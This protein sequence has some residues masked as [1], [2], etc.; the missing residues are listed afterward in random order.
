[1]MIAAWIHQAAYSQANYTISGKVLRKDNRPLSGAYVK[2]K[3]T[4]T[5]A[6]TDTAG[7]FTLSVSTEIASL[8]VS[9]TGYITRNLTVDVSRLTELLIYLEQEQNQLDE[10]TISTGYQQIPKERATGSFVQIDRDLLNRRVSTDFLSRLENVT[11]GLSFNRDAA[12]GNTGPNISI[13]GQSTIF[14]NTQPLI[15]IDNFPYDGNISNINPNDIESITVLKDA[16][17]ASIWGSRAGN[18]VIIITSKKG[19]FKRPMQVSVNANTTIGQKPDLFY[20]PQLSSAS[21]IEIEKTLFNKGYYQSIEK[22]PNHQALTPV[23][24][25]LIAA[26]DGKISTATASEQIDALKKI[27]VRNE[28]SR[29]FYRSSINQQYSINLDGGSDNQRYFLALGYDKNNSPAKGNNYER[30]TL[31][32]NTTYAWL[33]HKLELTAGIFINQS[34]SVNNNPG[35]TGIY[36]SSSLTNPFYPYAA[37]TDEN[38]KALAVTRNYRDDFT[39]SAVQNGLLDW[40]YRPLAELDI[41]DNTIKVNEYRLNAG[42]SYKLPLGLQANLLYQYNR[43]QTDGRNFQNVDAYYTRNLINQYTVAGAL[44]NRPIPFGGILDEN[45]SLLVAQNLRAQLN[46]ERSW[47]R[48]RITAIAGYEIKQASTTG[49]S[50]RLYGYD[51]QHASNAIVNYIGF[52]DRYDYPGATSQIPNRDATVEQNDHY[53]SYYANAA[54]N[55]FGKYTLSASI[56]KDESNIFG[57]N[58][59]QKGVPLWSAGLSWSISDEAFYHMKWLPYLKARI[60]YGYNGNVYKNISAYTTATYFSNAVSTQLPYA[61]IRN[62]PNPELRWERVKV[63]NFGMDFALKGDRL[64]GTIEYYFK[65]ASDLIGTMPFA[66]STGITTFTGNNASVY[67]QGIDLTL[68]TKNLQG[69]LKWLTTFLISHQTDKV[70]NYQQAPQTLPGIGTP[71]AGRPINSLYSYQWAGLDPSNGDPLGYLNNA[72]SKDYVAIMAK[73]ANGDFIY[74]GPA[75]PTTFGAI[76][77]TFSYGNFSLSANISF[78]MGYFYRAAS[79]RYAG[80]LTGTGGHSDYELRWQKPGDE[81]TTTI[82]S[83]PAAINLARDNFYEGASILVK[84]ADNIRLEDINVGYNFSR[85]N[86]HWLPV[87]SVQLYLYASNLGIIWKAEKGGIDPDYANSPYRPVKTIAIGLKASL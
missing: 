54:Y 33:D 65:Q 9:Y 68:N 37:L 70:I 42:L 46:F 13:R 51:P 84:K 11:S 17:A 16:A 21:F 24:E 26:R 23:V 35:I 38:G 43:Q 85:A 18:G 69:E 56:R 57:V 81:I 76:R 66:P 78:R 79:V 63:V 72:I 40:N 75:R 27:D 82:P 50:S 34:Q 41:A 10:V 49:K 3:D 4:H 60:T 47:R 45:N 77:N 30:L 32:S 61:T 29:Y 12:L 44:I 14:A 73:A 62:P 5:Q 48:H 7:K 83:M 55:Y 36:N 19:K 67:G 2:I 74:N 80:I 64:S 31:N 71:V 25:L 58:T 39:R 59:N 28:L 1:M 15:V 52:F 6:A 86:Q 8:I 22:S 87:R 53:L 20:Q